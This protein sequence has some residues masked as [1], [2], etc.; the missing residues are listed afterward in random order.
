MFQEKERHANPTYFPEGSLPK[1]ETCFSYYHNIANEFLLLNFA[2][3]YHK[4]SYLKA[5]T[6]IPRIGIMF[7][8]L[9]SLNEIGFK[10][11]IALLLFAI[12][13]QVSS[14]QSSY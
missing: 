12:G 7:T 4:I 5:N 13:F 2:R 8:Y 1:L 11:A 3:R 6:V 10:M 14:D 9:N